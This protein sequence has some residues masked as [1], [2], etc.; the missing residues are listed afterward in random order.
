MRLRLLSI[1]MFAFPPNLLNSFFR[2]KYCWNLR[3]NKR[4]FLRLCITSYCVD[5]P[6]RRGY[7]SG[8]LKGIFFKFFTKKNQIINF[9]M[10]KIYLYS[11]LLVHAGIISALFLTI[12]IVGSITYHNRQS[13]IKTQLFECGFENVNPL[14]YTSNNQIYVVAMFL[15]LYDAELLLLLP[16]SFQ[17][18]NF[19]SLTAVGFGTI[20]LLVIITCYWDVYAF[21]LFYEK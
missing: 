1:R 3:C 2:C 18:Y 6:Q 9:N 16:T 19:Y 11:F 15:L 10:I 14:I 13:Q 4:T 5:C 7:Y 17:M 8:R 12:S 20:V 21:S